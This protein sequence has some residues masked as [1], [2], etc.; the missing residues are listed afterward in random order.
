MDFV[1]SVTHRAVLTPAGAS[2]QAAFVA[3]VGVEGIRTDEQSLD[4]QV[5]G[6]VGYQTVAFHFANTQTAFA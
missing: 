3:D 5:R 4:E 1:H 6:A 2:Q